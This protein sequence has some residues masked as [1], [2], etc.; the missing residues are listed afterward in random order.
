MTFDLFERFQ[1]SV[2]STSHQSPANIDL[3]AACVCHFPGLWPWMFPGESKDVIQHT[4]KQIL[5]DWSL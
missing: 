3:L 1:N 5:A 4:I 2:W